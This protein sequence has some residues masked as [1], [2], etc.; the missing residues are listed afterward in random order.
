M[1][2]EYNSLSLV[3]S[4]YLSEHL[5][6]SESL[7]VSDGSGSSLLELNALKSLVHVK[8]VISASWLHLFVLS[9]TTHLYK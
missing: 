6:L 7:D 8:S 4:A 1:L 5:L 3:S 2:R 9:V